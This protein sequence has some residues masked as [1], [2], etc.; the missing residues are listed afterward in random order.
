MGGLQALEFQLTLARTTYNYM[1]TFMST[2]LRSGL[3]GIER[4]YYND[5][6]ATAHPTSDAE[7]MT[8]AHMN[9]AADLAIAHNRDGDST[10][11]IRG[12]ASYG[13]TG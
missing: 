9:H 13:W 8:V 3:V 2:Q 11:G 1:R 7:P 12:L 10:R 4:G 5:L 6:Y